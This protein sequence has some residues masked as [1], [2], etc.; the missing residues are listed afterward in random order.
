VPPRPAPASAGAARILVVDDDRGVRTL[1]ADLLGRS[2]YQVTP[3][4]SAEE[5]LVLCGRGI[6]DLVL[7][8]INLSGLDGIELCRRLRAQR[9]D[10]VVILITGYP[11]IE[12]AVRGMKEGARDYVTKPFSPDELR[13]VVGRALEER[14]LR[15]E[16]DR[17][18]R[19]L[20]F[21]GVI[22]RSTP[23]QALLATVEK[24]A[25]ADSSVLIIGESGTGKEL[26]ARALHY[27]G[28]RAGRPFVAVNCG[29]LVGT[30]LESELFGHVRGAFTGAIGTKRGLFVAADRGTLLLDEI[31]ELAPELQPKLLRALQEGEIKPVGGLGD[32]K[33]DVR[34]I[35]ATNRDLREDVRAGRF[36]EDLYYRLNVIT[37][38]IPPLRDRGG[39]IEPLAVHFAERAAV[40]ARKPTP[41]LSREAIAHL[42]AQPWPGNVRELA[43]AVERAVVLGGAILQPCD[44]AGRQPPRLEASGDEYPFGGMSLDALERA[45]IERVLSECNGQ[46]GRAAEILGINRTTLWKKLRQYG[47]D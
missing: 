33:V 38:E 2:G 23:I 39:D 42:E 22:G 27:H 29:P 34:V 36:R 32:I 19:E 25:R 24:V 3:A 35:A 1:C 10:Q 4:S 30:L 46:R 12:N 9:Q 37:L 7:A 6:F 15:Q 26:F 21:G 44:F 41:E 43:N 20:A 14:A 47:Y 40:R 5:A 17:L 45:H 13:I 18:R 28:L 11:S 16:N 31:A 8:D